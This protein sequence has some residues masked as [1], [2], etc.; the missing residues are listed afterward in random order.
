MLSA[1][2]F[3]IEIAQSW[4]AIVLGAHPV[5]E[6]V[7]N[8]AYALIGAVIFHWLVV[9]IPE[10]RRRRA[11]YVANWQALD[12]LVKMGPAQIALYRLARPASAASL[13]VW[14]ESSVRSFAA[15]IESEVPSFFDAWR[16]R[17]LGTAIMGVQ[18]ALEGMEGSRIFFDADVSHALAVYPSTKGFQQ[19]QIA[20]DAAGR[21]EWSRDAHIVW[22]LLEGSR[23]LYD[24]LRLSAPYVEFRIEE[25]QVSLSTAA[26]SNLQEEDLIRNR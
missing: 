13:D 9:Q 5:G 2:A 10:E 17:S 6:F 18:M 21:M 4:P 8:L 11:A 19:L 16:A 24:A 23:R 7:R 20:E 22:Q 12:L 26:Q 25:G 1:V 14:S 3:S 15:E